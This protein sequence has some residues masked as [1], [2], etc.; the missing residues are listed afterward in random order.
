MTPPCPVRVTPL[1]DTHPH[2]VYLTWTP[3]RMGGGEVACQSDS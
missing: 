2:H 1:T 3:G